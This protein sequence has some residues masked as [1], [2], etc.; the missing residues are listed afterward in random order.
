MSQKILAGKNSKICKLY[1]IYPLLCCVDSREVPLQQNLY[2]K[3]TIDC[4]FNEPN[5]F[6]HKNPLYIPKYIL[7]R[8]IGFMGRLFRHLIVIQ[9]HSIFLVASS[10]TYLHDIYK[11]LYKRHFSF[12]GLVLIQGS[13]E[14]T[15]KRTL[16]LVREILQLLVAKLW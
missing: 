15:Y 9:C 4:A 8:Y 7:N 1:C 11:L 6:L 12:L 3:L 5:F 14:C 16:K 2:Q 13:S 10:S